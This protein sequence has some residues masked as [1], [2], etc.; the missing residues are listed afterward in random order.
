MPYKEREIGQKYWTIGG[1]ADMFQ[2]ATSRIRFWEKYGLYNRRKHIP[3]KGGP[4]T[5]PGGKQIRERVLTVEGLHRTAELCILKDDVGMTNAG[6]KKA[7][8]LKYVGEI[9]KIY[10]EYNDDSEDNKT[11]TA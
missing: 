2:I 4:F 8:K 7:Y 11:G 1:V 9:I 5:L 6:M 10:S 3:R